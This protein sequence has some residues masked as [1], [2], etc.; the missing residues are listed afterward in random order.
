MLKALIKVR[1]VNSFFFIRKNHILV[2]QHFGGK[3][4]GAFNAPRI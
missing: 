2:T 3:I 4:D 1:T